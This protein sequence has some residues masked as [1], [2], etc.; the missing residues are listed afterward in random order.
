MQF[1]SDIHA[2]MFDD[3]D[4][5]Q[6]RDEPYHG[7]ILYSRVAKYTHYKGDDFNENI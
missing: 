2:R 5:K 1:F 4:E 6:K 7:L 3:N